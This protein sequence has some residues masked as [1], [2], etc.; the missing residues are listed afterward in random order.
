[1]IQNH[2][3]LNGKFALITGATKGIGRSIAEAFAYHGASFALTSRHSDEAVAAAAEINEQ[4]AR[5]AAIGLQSDLHDLGSCFAAYDEAVAHFGQIDI[6]VSNAAAVPSLFGPST[7]FPLEEHIRLLQANVAHNVAFMNHAAQAMKARRDGVILVTS[8][9]SGSRPS[10]GVFPYGVSKGGLNHAV[11]CLAAELAPFNVRVNAVA[12]GFTRSWGVKQAIEQD[13]S[14][15]DRFT[16]GVPL[17]RMIEPEEIAAG[18]VFLASAGGRA[19]TGQIV[20]MDG[21]DPAPGIST[22]RDNIV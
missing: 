11:R 15:V 13:P 20:M 21:G 10:N 22:D 19:M 7:E 5:E 1:V 9:A 2:F 14:V 6:L 8:S 3:D 18:M 17:R 16:Q 4:V 12:P